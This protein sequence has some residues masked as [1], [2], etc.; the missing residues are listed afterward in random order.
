MASTKKICAQ[1]G[2][3]IKENILTVGS[4]FFHPGCFICCK[5]QN[6]IKGSFKKKDG[7][8]ICL[9]CAP[10][11]LCSV[12]QTPVSGK[13]LKV[14][15][16]TFHVDCFKCVTCTE[17]LQSGFVT[18]GEQLY[19]SACAKDQKP[20][21]KI[22]KACIKC[23]K[24]IEP[25]EE[26]IT[27]IG[28]D[29]FHADCFVCAVCDCKLKEF[30]L[31]KERRASGQYAYLCNKCEEDA[32]KVAVKDPICVVCKLPIAP[33]TGVK[34][35][36]EVAMHYECIVCSVCHHKLDPAKTPHIRTKVAELKK[37]TYVCEG[38]TAAIDKELGTYGGTDK[39]GGAKIAYSIRLMPALRFWLDFNT[40]D[41]IATTS[42][43]AEGKYTRVVK[44]D[45]ETELNLEVE[46]CPFGG[47]P[48]AGKTFT[49]K[50][51]PGGILVCDNVRCKKS[52]VTDGGLES[53]ETLECYKLA[54]LQ[55]LTVC[56][57]L[58][59]DIDKRENRL[60]DEDFVEAFGMTRQEFQKMPKWKQN[61]KK[62]ALMLF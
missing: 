48:A 55:D 52:E 56:K 15:N 27:G 31:N 17:P 14:G 57:E 2:Q 5:C 53:G 35:F 12:C 34:L 7:G 51:E 49:V 23:K 60:S 13:I 39:R 3:E 50:A 41:A 32:N 40:A 37:G 62:K 19:C 42:W 59:V 45:T 58:H 28:G 10:D 44:S 33:D 20:G 1:C 26:T 61:D 9:D 4:E 54:Q 25:M 16:K 46:A 30:V 24:K 47:G 8:R 43:H 29:H 36:D 6:P 11:S 38:C 18:L 22:N 21:V